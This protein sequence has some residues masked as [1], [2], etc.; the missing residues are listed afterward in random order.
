MSRIAL[1]SKLID[2][3][4][5]QSGTALSDDVEIFLQLEG[6]DSC[7]YYCIDVATQSEFWIES[8]STELLDLPAVVSTSHL[9]TCGTY[10]GSKLC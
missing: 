4:L 2:E 5:Y 3:L 8:L 9:S 7:A 10:D 1:W 6:S